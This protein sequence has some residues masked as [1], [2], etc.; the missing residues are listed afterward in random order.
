MNLIEKFTGPTR[1][2]QYE[3]GTIWVNHVDDLE[4]IFYVQASEEAAHPNW[5]KL[6][7]YFKRLIQN[8]FQKQIDKEEILTMISDLLD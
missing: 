5:I 7:D 1:Y 4:S 3:F 8:Y 2:D 6:E